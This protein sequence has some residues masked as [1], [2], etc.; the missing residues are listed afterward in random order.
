MHTRRSQAGVCRV[1]SGFPN[2]R[3]SFIKDVVAYRTRI[4][5]MMAAAD[6]INLP[7]EHDIVMA[8]TVGKA[9]EAARERSGPLPLAEVI[10]RDRF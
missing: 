6:V 8:V 9:V 3:P 10:R 5:R 2:I 7:A 4:D 1:V